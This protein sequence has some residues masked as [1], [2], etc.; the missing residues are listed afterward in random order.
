DKQ[1]TEKLNAI[2][3]QGG[4]ID[5]ISNSVIS[6]ST[7][8]AIERFKSKFATARHIQYDP[9]SASGTLNANRESFGSSLIPSY[10]FSKARVIVS[11]SCD[12]LGSWHS[13][14][15]ATS[16]YASTRNLDNG[17]KEMSRHFQF[18][19][20]LSLTGANAD[21]R[22]PVKPS[23]EGLVAAQLYNII[24][25]A[26]LPAG[27]AIPGVEQ[28]AKELLAAKGQSIV[29]AGSNDKN[30]QVLVNAINAQLGNYGQTINNDRPVNY[31]KGDD[32]AMA[33]FV[34]DLEGGKT[35]GVI[36]YNCNP[37]YDHPEGSRIAASLKNS[38]V[39]VST[40]GTENETATACAYVAPD[41]HYLESWNDAEPVKGSFSLSQ[42]VIT[43]LFLTRHAQESLLTWAGET[44]VV[45]FNV[46]KTN[47]KNW[48]FQSSGALDFQMFWDKCLYD[49]VYEPSVP[50][51]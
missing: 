34:S 46:V 1:V 21:Y 24:A 13:A 37:V 50:A 36:F 8:A 48:F 25:G 29:V 35:K 39:S 31:R 15:T 7:Q 49:G 32:A 44:G 26:S 10:D 9:I 11:I 5:L 47:W 27:N 23:Q 19:S 6:P 17:K 2:A 30:V 22:T 14:I 51:A 40:S 41:H 33:S 28:A 3:A 20:N 12:F 4:Q 42:P 18:E 43:P 45:Y 38:S 16:Q